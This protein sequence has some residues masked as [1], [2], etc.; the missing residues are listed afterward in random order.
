MPSAESQLRAPGPPR[1]PLL[2]LQQAPQDLAARALGDGV[3]E[4]DAAL[5]PLVPGLVGLDVR[6][7]VAGDLG[8][9]LAG[10]HGRRGPHHVGLGHLA[11]ALVRHRD[12]GAVVHGRVRQEVRLELSGGDLVALL[13]KSG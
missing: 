7:D 6:G 9:G 1:L 4:L 5:E 8:V 13:G 12:H 11:R 3:D 2:V 10:G